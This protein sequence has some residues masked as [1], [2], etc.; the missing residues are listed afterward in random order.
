MVI[1]IERLKDMVF[2]L[3][4]EIFNPVILLLP[5]QTGAPGTTVDGGQDGLLLTFGDE[6]GNVPQTLDDGDIFQNH[7]GCSISMLNYDNNYTKH[8]NNH[9][10]RSSFALCSA[11]GSK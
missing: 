3:S 2:Y 7:D 5:S 9:S 1:G 11:I 6:V 4:L 10:F 8:E